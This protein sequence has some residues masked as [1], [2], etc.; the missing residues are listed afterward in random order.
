M[1]AVR[2]IMGQIDTSKKGD[3]L[4][5]TIYVPADF[6]KLEG[7]LPKATYEEP[8][9]AHAKSNSISM[10]APDLAALR[11]NLSELSINR[12]PNRSK[13]ITSSAKN[14]SSRRLLSGLARVAS[15]ERKVR[16][17][18]QSIRPAVTHKRIASDLYAPAR[19]LRSRERSEATI[20]RA[21][22]EINPTASLL[23]PAPLI[24]SRMKSMNSSKDHGTSLINIG[25]KR[26]GRIELL[27]RVDSSKMSRSRS[28]SRKLNVLKS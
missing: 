14:T 11:V 24:R 23:R 22:V 12:E 15:I 10:V 6:N 1:S 4:L 3:S 2:K 7:K 13:S 20:R 9:I 19:R 28:K 25:V 21:Q 26:S 5:N 16:L 18:K 8:E 27:R 17:T